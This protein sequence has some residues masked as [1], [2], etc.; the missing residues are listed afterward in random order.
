MWVK[1]VPRLGSRSMRSSS[2]CSGSAARLG[3]TW[4]PMQPRF[5]AHATCAMS[6]ATSASDV[7]PFGVLTTVV[8]SHSGASLG[9]RFW[10]NDGPSAP[11]GNRCMSTGRPPIARISG[12]PTRT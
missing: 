3:H 12:S 8:C 7:V 2:A 9:T 4:N 6:A 5:T 11:F 10:K 1:S